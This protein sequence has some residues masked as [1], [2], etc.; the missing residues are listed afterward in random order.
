V[1]ASVTARAHH[2]A[3]TCAHGVRPV[4]PSSLQADLKVIE[5][6]AQHYGSDDPEEIL[7]KKLKSSYAGPMVS[8]HD[9][10]VS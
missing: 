8:G 5:D 2:I 6:P 4:K 9:L 10:D 7:L 3:A 1:A